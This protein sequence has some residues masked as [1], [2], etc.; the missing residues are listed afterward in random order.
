METTFFGNEYFTGIFKG[1]ADT[2]VKHGRL[3]C[4]AK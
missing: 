2:F 1:E 4:T 3:V